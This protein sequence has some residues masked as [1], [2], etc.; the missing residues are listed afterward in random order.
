[1][2]NMVAIHGRMTA[3][4]ELKTTNNGISVVTFTLACER[5]WKKDEKTVTDFIPCVAWRHT[6]EFVSKYFHKGQLTVVSGSLQSR[7]WTDK[8]GNKHT[9]WEVQAENVYFGEK[10][11]KQLQE[12]ADDGE[13]PF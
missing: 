13:L 1:M 4:P 7:Q 6:A 5:D 12:L 9:S 3:D 8:D 2:L 10:R 11:E